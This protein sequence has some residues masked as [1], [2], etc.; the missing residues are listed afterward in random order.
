MEEGNHIN[1]VEAVVDGTTHD[2][3]YFVEQNVIHALI[4]GKTYL[5]P[6]GPAGAKETVKSLLT[7]MVL[8]QDRKVNAARGSQRTLRKP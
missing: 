6:I 3:S 8:E 2:A 1:N 5:S 7:A 4:N